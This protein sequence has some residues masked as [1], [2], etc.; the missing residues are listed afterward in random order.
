MKR[1]FRPT[2]LVPVLVVL[3]L[4]A[5]ALVYWP[6][7][8]KPMVGRAIPQPVPERDQEVAWLNNATSGVA[9]ERFVA[10]VRRLNEKHPD[11]GLQVAEDGNAFPSHTTATP[12]LAVKLGSS[13]ARVWFRWYKLTGDTGTGEWVKALGQRRPPPLA[14]IGGSSSDRARDLA[15]ELNALQAGLPSPP[16]LLITTATA[17]QVDREEGGHDL[18][19]IYPQRSF[20]FCYTNRQMAEAVTEFIWQHPDLRPD[21]EPVYSAHWEDDPYSEDLFERF[22]EV[23]GPDRFGGR[24]MQARTAQGVARDVGWLAGHLAGDGILPGLGLETFCRPPGPYWSMPIPYSVGNPDQ[25]NRWEVE[26]AERLMDERDQHLTQRK[27]LLVLP[28]IPK[29]AYRFLHALVRIS[30]K[31]ARRFIVATGDAIDFDT[32]YRDRNLKWPIQDSAFYPR[33][34]LSPQSGRPYR[35]STRRTRPGKDRSGPQRPNFHR[36]PGLDALPGHCGN[37]REGRLPGQAAGQR[38]RRVEKEPS[39]DSIAG[40]PHPF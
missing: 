26:A 3:I 20:R 13:Q 35:F 36:H 37:R 30:H 6:L 22:H 15:R 33:V 21:S 19:G 17:D 32:V 9:W 25:P 39:R 10:A 23:L 40:R 38:R 4:G 18:M 16:V 27:P 7:W 31:E 11:L 12:E 2:I 5:T 8:G 29:P 24:M 14:I 28:A 1:L 34:F